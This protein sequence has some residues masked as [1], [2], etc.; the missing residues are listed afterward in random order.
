LGHHVG[1]GVHDAF[2]P[3]MPLKA[4]MVVTIEPGL[5]IAEENIGVRIEDMVLITDTGARV[6][7][8]A[9]PKQAREIERLLR[10]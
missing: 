2:D 5:Y 3:D 7:S 10:R 1:L 4:G 6:L 8:G 9:L